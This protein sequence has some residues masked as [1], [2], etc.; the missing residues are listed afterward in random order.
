MIPENLKDRVILGLII[1]VA[2]FFIGMIGSCSSAH[3][4][5]VVRDK[6]MA[7]RLDLEEKVNGF[8]QEKSTLEN[9]LNSVTQE[10]EK[11]KTAHQETNKALLQE[12][13]VNQ[14]LQ[15]E[16]KKLTKLKETLEE[17]LKEALT[18]TKSKK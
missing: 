8:T 1:L 9:K 14:S 18:S 3:R 12:Q 13:L 7:T 6:E 10:L 4:L 2:I 15:E 11:E 16:I 5:K 17:D